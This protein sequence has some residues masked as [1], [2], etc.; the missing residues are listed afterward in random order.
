MDTRSSVLRF[1]EVT[2]EHT[3]HD[4]V[5]Q[6]Y[7][8]DAEFITPQS[9]VRGREAI[10]QVYDVVRTA[11]PDDHQE[12]TM[13]AIDGEVGVFEGFYSVTH[14]GPLPVD[15]AIV[16]ATG[17]RWRGRFIDVLHIVDGLIVSHRDYF[18]VRDMRQQ[19]GIPL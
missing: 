16:E 10:R 19:L 15:G 1:I 7:A 2:N 3:S 13:L 11:F 14:L 6:L 9:S 4:D 8:P 5:M 18:D 12:I 17:R